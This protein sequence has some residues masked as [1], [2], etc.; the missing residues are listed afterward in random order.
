MRPAP[1]SWVAGLF[2]RIEALSNILS[3]FFLPPDRSAL[4]GVKPLQGYNR[5][6]EREDVAWQKRIAQQF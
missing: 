5:P 1:R 6:I 4:A 3:G 2:L